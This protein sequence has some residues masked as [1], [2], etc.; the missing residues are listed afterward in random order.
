MTALFLPLV[1]Q[2]SILGRCSFVVS[3]AV[4]RLSIS[5]STPLSCEVVEN[6]STVFDPNFYGLKDP[7]ICYDSLLPWFTLYRVAKFE[8]C[9]LNCVC[10]AQQ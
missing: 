1:D 8:F 2:T 6:R 4:S 9:R 10:E 3:N 7:K 5:S